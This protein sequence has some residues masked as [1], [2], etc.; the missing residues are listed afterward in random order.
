M[1]CIPDN[2][3]IGN[4]GARNNSLMQDVEEIRTEPS[5][6]WRRGLKRRVEGVR[7]GGGEWRSVTLLL[8]GGLER[9]RVRRREGGG[10]VKNNS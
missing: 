8:C 5:S 3:T 6:K 7:G 1:K 9:E 10:P 2:A 4:R